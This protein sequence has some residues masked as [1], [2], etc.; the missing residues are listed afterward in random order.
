VSF[1]APLF[2]LGVLAVAGPII[3][4]L[5]RRTTREVTPFSSLM[6]LAPTP[7]RVTRRSRIE[8]LWLLLLRCAV[9]GLLAFGFARPF[10]KQQIASERT[11][12][13]SGKRM[14]VLVDASASMRREDLWAQAR[15]RV[16]AIVREAKPV[17]EMA[18]LAFDRDARS[19]FSFDEWGRA[20]A[21]DRAAAILQR[22]DAIKPG[23]SATNL[24]AALLNAA[25][26]LD[27]P[28]D[29]RG[30]GREIV[31]VSDMQEG[32]RFDGL[33]GYEWPRGCHVRLDSV[34]AKRLENAAAHW[35]LDA[36]DTDTNASPR[37]RVSNGADAKREQFTLEWMA[38]NPGKKLDVYV[39]AGQ[40]RIARPQPPPA[41]ATRLT[42]A[43]D[44]VDFDNALFILPPQP[45]QIPLL[46]VGSDANEDSAGLF[47]F[48]SRAFQ[49]TPALHVALSA[50]RGDAPVPAF[51]L[52]QAQMIVLGAH[53]EEAALAGIRQFAR[54]GKAVLAPMTTVATAE[55]L[56][57][58]LEVKAFTADE[59]P[60]KDYAMLAQIDFTHPLFATFA[61]PRFSDFTKI[62]F[63]K[64]RRFDAAALPSARVIASFE[65]KAPAIVEAPLGQGRV[66]IFASSWTP[67][68]SQL[69][70]STKFVPL[71]YALLEQS[72]KL[73]PRKA[74]YFV[75]D[76]VPLP[77]A[78]HP[79]TI[80]KPDG[81]EV[82]APAESNFAGA[83]QPGVYAVT[84]G[85]LRFVV[86]LAP[87][88]SSL[89]PLAGERLASLGV[90]LDATAR[91]ST[92]QSAKEMARAQA[93][94]LES[95]QKLWRWLIVA[96]LAVLF[97]ETLLAGRLT[98]ALPSAAT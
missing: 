2:F 8:N 92:P 74:Q 9:I 56:A 64:Y 27:A 83:D 29:D 11:D 55:T 68:D 33:Q 54:D 46:Y 28:A 62:H 1:L 69:A 42:L 59:A 63:W 60:V 13:G 77:P 58:L 87:E 3:F 86:N 98:R 90:P 78:P 49:K 35:V 53:V 43:G 30:I 52:Q 10:L 23:W 89:A 84:P 32:S 16:E 50:V 37:I 36:N 19:I 22:L 17:D 31:I 91:P 4:H 93:A 81:T 15:A 57:R 20:S 61:D 76:E 48:L 72:S 34:K 44:E 95:R 47:Y 38:A 71:L 6:F 97:V 18:L 65:N 7:P 51:Q 96:A 79:F 26:M 24:A 66:V 40:S 45:L 70:L 14:V 94:E 82:T 67:S 85:A 75:G 41:G 21:D 39:P 80:R 12:A 5:I 25:E 73:P 88:E